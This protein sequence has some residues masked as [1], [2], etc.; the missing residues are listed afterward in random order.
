MAES[1]FNPLSI[2]DGDARWEPTSLQPSSACKAPRSQLHVEYTDV[3]FA[4][5]APTLE[6]LQLGLQLMAMV[7]TD[8]RIFDA[9]QLP[10]VSSW[11]LYSF[12]RDVEV[13]L[14]DQG[15]LWMQIRRLGSKSD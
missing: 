13:S 9:Q 11:I 4:T 1:T 12:S 15:S 14:Q 5:S 8:G 7:S 10:L 2:L 3:L 6:G